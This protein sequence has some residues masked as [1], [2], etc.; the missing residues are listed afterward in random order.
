MVGVWGSQEALDDHP[1]MEVIELR[2][3][4]NG[5][6]DGQSQAAR[7]GRKQRTGLTMPL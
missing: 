6:F 3:A 7:R 5:Y 2:V 1:V 4:E